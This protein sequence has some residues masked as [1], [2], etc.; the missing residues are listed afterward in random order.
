MKIWVLFQMLMYLAVI[1][2][3]IWVIKWKESWEGGMFCL[4][5]Y[6]FE[7]LE[8]VFVTSFFFNDVCR[9][10]QIPLAGNSGRAH[11]DLSSSPFPWGRF[12]ECRLVGQTQTPAA[13]KDRHPKH[14]PGVWRLGGSVTSPPPQAVGAAAHPKL[15]DQKRHQGSVA[16]TPHPC[17]ERRDAE[18][19]VGDF[20]TIIPGYSIFFLFL[21]LQQINF[22]LGTRIL[23]LVIDAVLKRIEGW[24]MLQLF[25]RAS[26][27]DLIPSVSSEITHLRI[28]T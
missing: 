22:F 4:Q 17:R 18:G 15:G 3:K 11:S 27:L 23:V 16:I 21:R 6:A 19:G 13:A 5:P 12:P 10:K 20:V 7:H 14:L 24:G 1:M 2:F 26:D 28:G 9:L 25:F 8:K